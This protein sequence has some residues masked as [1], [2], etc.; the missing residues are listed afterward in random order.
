LQWELKI[1]KL[2]TLELGFTTDIYFESRPIKLKYD[3][4]AFSKLTK[5]FQTGSNEELRDQAYNKI[6]ALKETT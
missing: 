2:G 1:L 4:G 3:S 6:T 5:F